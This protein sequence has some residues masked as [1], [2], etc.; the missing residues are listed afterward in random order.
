MTHQESFQTSLKSFLTCQWCHLPCREL[1]RT[2]LEAF[3]TCQCC[4]LP[5][6]ECFRTS[7]EA[8]LTSQC[9]HLPCLDLRWTCLEHF[10]SCPERFHSRLERFLTGVIALKYVDWSVRRAFFV[11]FALLFKRR[12]RSTDFRVYVRLQTLLVMLNYPRFAP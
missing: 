2:S 1:L 6:R 4:H 8:F 3:L 11:D 10:H 7:L 12:C 9:C 5:Y